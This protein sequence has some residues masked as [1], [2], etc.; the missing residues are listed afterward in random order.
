MGIGIG[1]SP[2]SNFETWLL[3]VDGFKDKVK[4]WWE[5]FKVN[6]R[7]DYVLADKF[8]MLKAKIKEWRKYNRGGFIQSTLLV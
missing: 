1:K 8:K 3:E 2:T 6:D 4:E 5:F 7:S